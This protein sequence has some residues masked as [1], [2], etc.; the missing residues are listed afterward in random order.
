MP[1]NEASILTIGQTDSEKKITNKVLDHLSNINWENLFFG[2]LSTIGT[3]AF[4]VYTWIFASAG[5]WWWAWA[6]PYGVLTLL[7][8]GFAIWC[9]MNL[10][11][12]TTW[13]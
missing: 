2:T 8:G 7:T 10:F 12:A 4:G 5:G 1:L 13:V 11:G 9:F 6:I 3:L